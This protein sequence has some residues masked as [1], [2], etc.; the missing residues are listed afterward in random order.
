MWVK[1]NGNEI[2]VFQ[3]KMHADD[4]ELV[5]LVRDSLGIKVKV[6][7]YNHQNRHY[8]VFLVRKRKVIADVIIPFFD[9]VLYGLKKQQFEAWKN[10][11]I[12]FAATT[13]YKKYI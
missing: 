9:G 13:K 5:E 2:P 7:E 12:D 11:F 3:L 6:H 4:K 8:V 1:Q 10:K